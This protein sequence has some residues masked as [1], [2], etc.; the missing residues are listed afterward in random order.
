MPRPRRPGRGQSEHPE[1]ENSGAA[2]FP[3]VPKRGT[4]SVTAWRLRDLRKCLPGFED[5]AEHQLP[6]LWGQTEFQVN[7]KLGLTS[8][9]CNLAS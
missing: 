9:A 4:V 5:R 7:L 2:R 1:G 3:C 6:A 8:H